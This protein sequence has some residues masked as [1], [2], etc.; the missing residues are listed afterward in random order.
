M[1][2][3]LSSSRAGLAR[4]G[5]RPTTWSASATRS[6]SSARASRSAAAIPTRWPRSPTRSSSPEDRP[7]DAQIEAVLDK[8][9]QTAW[10]GLKP[11][12]YAWTAV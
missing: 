3:E 7:T 10:A 9:E 11:D 5:R 2:V 6:G 8:F 1:H 12:R 4:P